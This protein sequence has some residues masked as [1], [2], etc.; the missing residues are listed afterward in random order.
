[1]NQEEKERLVWVKL[2]EQTKDAGSQTTSQRTG[3]APFDFPVCICHTQDFKAERLHP[4]CQTKPPRKKTE[5]IRYCRPVPGERIRMDTCKIAPRICTKYTAIDDCTRYRVFQIYEK[6]T[7][8]STLDFLDKVLEHLP[9]PVQ[10]IQTDRGMEFFAE[11]VQRRLMESVS[12][13]AQ[14]SLVGR[15]LTARS[16]VPRKRTWR[17]FTRPSI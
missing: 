12:S 11:K 17:S 16:N 9:F 7:A 6:R 2:Y 5:Y 13:S 1:M 14:T 3:T 4:P 15:T 10:R 8:D